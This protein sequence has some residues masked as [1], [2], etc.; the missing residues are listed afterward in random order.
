VVGAAW[1]VASPTA[2][3]WWR[4]IV[5]IDPVA[6]LVRNAAHAGIGDGTYDLRQLALAALDVAVASTGFAREAILD[7]VV[8]TLA[9]I[10]GRMRSES[11]QAEQWRDVAQL[12]VMG[13]L[14]DAHEQRRFSSTFAGLT[15]PGAV[16]WDA[17]GFRRLPL[18]DADYGVEFR[19]ARL[20]RG[21]AHA[22]ARPA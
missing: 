2:R 22:T 7:E 17:C 11:E 14:S 4:A 13:L 10:A 12:V 15:N 1:A 3:A 21:W 5:L 8:D 18:R 6:K 20:P 19:V 16:R 9:G